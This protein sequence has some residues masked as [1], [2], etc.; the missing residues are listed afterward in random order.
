MIL[1]LLSYTS[2]SAGAD[3]SRLGDVIRRVAPDWSYFM[4]RPTRGSLRVSRGD[5]L[6]LGRRS[7]PTRSPTS[8]VSRSHT[9][10]GITLSGHGTPFWKSPWPEV[11]RAFLAST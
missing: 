11:T 8:A 4:R 7:R 5:R 2:V 1:K 10:R 3:G 9:T 6:T